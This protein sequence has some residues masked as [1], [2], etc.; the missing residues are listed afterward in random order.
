MNTIGYFY[1]FLITH[2]AFISPRAPSRLVQSLPAG[3]LDRLRT[4]SLSLNGGNLRLACCSLLM[5]LLSA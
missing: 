5:R 2:S 1:R 4:L 3:S